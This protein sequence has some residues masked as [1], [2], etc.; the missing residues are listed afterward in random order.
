MHPQRTIRATLKKSL[1]V[2]VVRGIASFAGAAPLLLA[3]AWAMAAPQQ[4]FDIAPG[5]LAG[6]LNQFGQA[7]HILLSYPAALTQGQTS[8]GLQGRHDL[9]TG[10]AILLSN[11]SLQAVR[12]SGDNYSLQPR[13]ADGALQ[14]GTVSISGKAPGSTTEGTGSYTTQSSSSST[15]LNLT[16]RE[17]PQSLTVMTRQRLDDQRLTNLSDTL[18]A[19]PGIIVLRDGLGSESDAYFSRGFQ[20]Q[21]F[22]IDGVPTVTRMDNYTQSMAMYDR[23]EVVRGATGL[24]SGMGNPSATIN[25]IRKRP[26]AEARA[27]VTAEAG[28][29]DRYGSGL[30]VSGP[31]TETGNVRG[32]LVAD[33]KTEHAW[34]DRYKQ[35]TQLLYGITEFDLTEDTLLTMGLSY[36]RTDVDA[37]A[38]SGLPTRFTDG[39]RSNLSRSLNTA[40]AWSYNDHEQTS[41]FTS[42]EQKF[43]SGWSAKA[44]FTH[45][46]NKFDEVFNYVNGSLNSDGSGTTQL[47]VR[48][49]GTPRQDNLDLYAT[50]PFDLLGREHELIAGVTLS[51][52]KENVPSHGGWNYAYSGSPAGAI[53]NLFN[54]DGHSVKPDFPVTGK[55]SVDESQYAAYLSTRLRM[56]DDLSVIL[57]SRVIDWKRETQDSPYGGV[58]TR[59]S[60]SETGVYIPYAGVVYDL[61]D[62]WSAYASYTKIFNPQASWVRDI[63]N[64]ALEPM[65]GKGYELGLKGSF[66]DEQLNTSLALFKLEQ[67]NL[68]IWIDTPGG[69]TYRNEKGTTTEGVE[70]ELNG[71]LAEGW[72]ASAGYAYAVSTDA[73]DKRIVTTLPRQS[74]KTFTTY[75]LP[76][77]LSKVTVGGGVNWQSK[78]GE[79]LHTFSQGS[80]AITNLLLRYDVT[81]QLST[82]VNLNNLFDREYFSYA[83]NHG[84]YGAPRNLMTSIKYDF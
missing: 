13:P 19:T 10:L 56:T 29:W 14:L 1:A 37:P 50:G 8:P 2:A 46:Q 38:R 47:P 21:N 64:K 81:P 72:Q 45:S 53:D 82:S 12:G 70:L 79:D 32:R 25:L 67:D 65:E 84:M 51:K 23:V 6:A 60:E 43:D 35:Q 3:P 41:F 71:E 20:I 78:V 54:W 66:F 16:P 17:T 77:A 5:S 74:L 55:S 30:D 31:L 63:N 83:G 36:L 7:T 26:T 44:E 9:D 76:G 18:D 42:I 39:S 61:T 27:S 80:Y 24:I 49:S 52:Y 62:N 57:G 73:D 34:V 11:S 48:F 75:R 15:R 40:P 28:N 58:A 22:E 4:E 33:Y 69:N 59:T 68:A